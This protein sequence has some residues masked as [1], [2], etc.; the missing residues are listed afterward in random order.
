MWFLFS[1]SSF[2]SSK[3]RPKFVQHITTTVLTEFEQQNGMKLLKGSALKF[4]PFEKEEFWLE[5]K[6]SRIPTQSF[7]FPKPSFIS[8]NS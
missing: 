2:Y 3:Y 7:F 6:P 1:I 8:R 5:V 4:I